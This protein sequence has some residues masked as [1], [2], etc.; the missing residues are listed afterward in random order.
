MR[1]MLGNN[2]VDFFE[3]VS[4][5]EVSIL[6]WKTHF[7][8]QTIDLVDDHSYLERKFNIPSINSFLQQYSLGPSV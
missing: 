7:Q 5:L 3:S 1:T 6:R 8:N 4:D 2:S